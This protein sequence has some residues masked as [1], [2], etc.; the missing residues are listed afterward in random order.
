MK[1]RIGNDIRFLITIK[2][3]LHDVNIQSMRAYIVNN[4]LKSKIE[5]EL[6]RKTKFISRYPI[7]PM[8]D[9]YISTHYNINGCGHPCYNVYPHYPHRKMFTPYA[10]FGVNPAF[11][12]IY[13]K[14]PDC[15]YIKYCAK[16][17][18]TEDRDKIEVIFPAEAQHDLGEY[19][20]IL[21]GKVYRPGY[22][23]NVKTITVGYDKAFEL[24]CPLCEE[25]DYTGGEYIE[26]KEEGEMAQTNKDTY[27]ISGEFTDDKLVLNM[28][29][30]GK[31]DIDRPQEDP[32]YING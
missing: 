14:A 28:S 20:I 19:S 18:Y 12:M 3:E 23:Q 7:E 27:V 4:T 25:E 26:L 29:T 1:I 9:S 17:E 11:E 31:V 13:P 2:S 21:T 8:I 6:E 30:G 32:W 16:V 10:G 24:V 22:D 5:A 15:H